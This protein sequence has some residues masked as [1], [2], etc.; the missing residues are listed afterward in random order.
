MFRPFSFD[1]VADDVAPV[2]PVLADEPDLD[3]NLGFDVPEQRDAETDYGLPD[4]VALVR[5]AIAADLDSAVFAGQQ[6]DTAPNIIEWCRGH[7]WLNY[8]TDLF[9][10]QIQVLARFFEDVCYFCSDVPYVHNARVD[11]SASDA[12][13][14]FCLLQHGVCPNCQRNRTEMLADWFKDPRYQ[15]LYHWDEVVV[16]RPVPPNE[17]VGIWGQRS[18][19]SITTSSFIWTY[20]LHRLVALPSPTRYFRLPTNVVLQASFVSPTREQG[21]SNLWQPFLGAYDASPWFKNVAQYLK[22]ESKRTGLTLYHRQQTFLVFPG[23]RLAVHVQAANSANLRGATRVFCLPGSTLINTD[24]GLLPLHQKQALLSSRVCIAGK[25]YAIAAHAEVGKRPLVRITLNQG[26]SMEATHDHRVKVLGKD[27][28]VTWKQAGKLKLGDYVAVNLGT[29]FPEI[30]PLAYVPKRAPK[31]ILRAYEF[32]ERHKDLFY[33]EDLRDYAGLTCAHT[34]TKDLMQRGMLRKEFIVGQGRNAGC[35]FMATDKFDLALLTQELLDHKFKG[36][37]DAT[38]PTE[39]TEDLGYLLGYYVSEG[40]YAENAVEFTFSNTSERVIE[41]F[42]GCF[43]RTFGIVPR[44]SRCAPRRAGAKILYK[45]L[46]AYRVVKDFFRY[47]GMAPS[48]APTKSVPWSILQAPKKVVL[49]FLSAFIEGDGSISDKYVSAFSCSRVLLQQIQLLLLSLNVTSKIKAAKSSEDSE[50]DIIHRRHTLYRLLLP[51]FSSITLARQLSC[52]TKG[53]HFNF[54]LGTMARKEYKVPH[55]PSYM[56]TTLHGGG[57]V[58]WVYATSSINTVYDNFALKKL[59][60]ENPGKYQRALALIDTSTLW[61]PVV[62]LEQVGAET[63]YDLTVASDEHAFAANGIMVHNCSADE[64]AHFNFSEDGKHRASI[65]NGTEVYTSLSNSLRTVR[66]AAENRRRQLGDYDAIDGYMVNI[67]SPLDISDPIEQRAAVA[68]KSFRMYCTRYPTWEVNPN[69]R[70]DLIRE[71]F[72]GNPLKFTRDFGAQPPMATNPFI[73]DEKVVDQIVAEKA[74]RVCDVSVQTEP[75][76][77]GLSLLRPRVVKITGDRLLPRCIAVDN[78]ERHNS[79]ALCIARYYPEQDGMLIEELIEVAPTRQAS[80]DL[81]YC[82]NDLVVPL[83]KQLKCVHVAYDRWESGYA[84]A[85]L[86]T[87]HKVDAQR[88]SSKWKDFDL[89]R[90]DLLGL[91]IFMAKPEVSW[92]QV[93]ATTDL[94]ERAQWPRAHFQAQLLTVNEFVKHLAKPLNGN[95]DLF[96]TVVLAHHF[97]FKYR[98]QYRHAIK[99]EG[100]RDGDR[101]VAMWFGRSNRGARGAVQRPGGYGQAA[102]AGGRGARR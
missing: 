91:R 101:P 64:L 93:L 66:S 36:R 45:V 46:I 82:Y 53:K 69:E 32:I 90:Q 21:N 74:Q 22:Q 26:Q 67:S 48:K 62:K 18:G 61:F 81:A 70:E 39:M 17:F 87:N 77:D 95:D 16:P 15:D 9:A 94:Q 40:S 27:L 31:R 35:R 38:F 20:I 76:Q 97:I 89:F 86:R 14:H 28:S 25:T 1:D 7:Q 80:V 37:D 65:R 92:R 55:V 102:H 30:L 54:T 47:L 49:A 58:K 44:V 59:Q 2:Q 8:E 79:F 19:K 63:V 96:R 99:L 68:S 6:F 72:A 51:R 60:V 5:Q 88:Y 43:A 23:K 29:K 13:D 98:E 12:L 83:V 100:G 42:T 75:Q 10:R 50:D 41:H 78:G 34:I 24:H 3:V 4:P 56:D 84:V 71:E 33:T 11:D 52:P 85:D 73:Q 57:V